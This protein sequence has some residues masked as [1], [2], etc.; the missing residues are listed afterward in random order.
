VIRLFRYSRS[1]WEAL[2]L[3]QKLSVA[4]VAMTLFPL[5]LSAIFT[6][7]E[8]TVLMRQFVFDRNKNLA[9]NIAHDVDQLFAEKIRMMKVVVADPDFRSMQPARQTAVL[10]EMVKTYE[11]IHIA[12]VIDPAGRQAARSDGLAVAASIDYSD[13]GYFSQVLKSQ[14]TAISDVLVS[15]SAG[16]P[17]VVIAEPIFGEDRSLRGLLLVNIGL[18]SIIRLI[19]NAL[20]DQQGYVYVV[21]KS[22]KVIIHTD[23]MQLRPEETFCRT[24]SDQALTG[25][26]GWLEYE[27]GGQSILAGYSYLPNIGWGLVVERSLAAAMAEVHDVQKANVFIIVLAI[28]LAILTSLSIAQAIAGRIGEISQAS[29]RV[30]AGDFKTRLK[31]ERTDE[32]GKLAD[33]FNL[34]TEQLAQRTADLCASEA[35]FRSLVENVNIGVYQSSIE[36]DGRFIQVNPAMVQMFD[37]PAMAM[38]LKV[39]LSQLYHEATDRRC[40][41]RQ[42]QQ[43]GFVK[44]Q[45]CLMRRY[46]GETFWCS[47]SAVARKDEDGKIQWIEGVIEDI[48]E[49]KLAETLMRK[50]KEE[51]EVQVVARTHELT[52]LNEELYRL[53]LSDGLT[54]I[55]NRRSLDELLEREWK[56]AE[57]E[58]TTLAILMIDLDFFKLFND[59]YGH[60]AGD[61]CLKKVAVAIQSMIKR[62]TDFVGRY[63][64]EE[65]AV[66]L[67]AT[68]VSGAMRVGEKIRVAVEML[69][70]P[71]QCSLL[72]GV[73]TVSI[74]VA[75]RTPERHSKAVVLLEAADQA[76]Y[77][78]K[79][80]G[81]NQVAIS[82]EPAEHVS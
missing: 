45:E 72:G 49:R 11:G 29:L 42:L 2:N 47:R 18:S 43:K 14:T 9:L 58:Q 53:S 59:T 35:R 28:L 68:D 20:V 23:P 19:E 82:G 37:Y 78:A 6:E 33:N 57:R 7:W 10:Q 77:R 80:A 12:V 66:I 21:N 3:R 63:G 4:F 73:V 48:T 70:I 62:T 56:R 17:G 15:K 25:E 50:A 16:W 64:G 22:G 67:P 51:L 65:F 41:L 60:L 61:E 81:R 44:N 46:S 31:I 55:G 71:H 1:R 75:S 24:P 32:I 36:E 5:L 30:A 13:R 38:L 39:P 79:L 34:M 40:F 74:G 69:A 8:T 54:G 76:L 52:I 27:C 26:T